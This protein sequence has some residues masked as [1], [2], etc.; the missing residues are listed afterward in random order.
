MSW[1]SNKRSRVYG[2][3]TQTC[4]ENISVRRLMEEFGHKE[5]ISLSMTIKVSCTFEF[6]IFLSEKWWKKKL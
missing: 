6:D 1:V 4:K 5:E 2:R 3:A